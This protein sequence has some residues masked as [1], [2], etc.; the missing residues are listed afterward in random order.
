MRVNLTKTICAKSDTNIVRYVNSYFPLKETFASEIATAEV[1]VTSEPT[2]KAA[3]KKVIAITGRRA[4]LNKFATM[5]VQ[6]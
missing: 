3:A 4:F 5:R 2:E 6:H 1:D